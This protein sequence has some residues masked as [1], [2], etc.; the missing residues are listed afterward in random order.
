M[1][2]SYLVACPHRGCDWVGSLL[3]C[4]NTEAW[5]SLI[6]TTSVAVFQCPRCETVWRAR[7]V[8]D[9]VKPL[10]AEELEPHLV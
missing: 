3:P 4:R 2:T 9:D 1:L 5:N 7:I 6:P 10:P 8:G